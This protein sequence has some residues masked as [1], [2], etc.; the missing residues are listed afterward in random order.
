[1]ALDLEQRDLITLVRGA[2]MKDTELFQMA[3]GIIPPWLVERF[4]FDPEEKRRDIYIVDP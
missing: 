3:L 2:K 4:G 1:M